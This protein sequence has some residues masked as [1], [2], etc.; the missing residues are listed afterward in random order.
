VPVWNLEDPNQEDD[1]FGLTYD[2]KVDPILDLQSRQVV[3]NFLRQQLDQFGKPGASGKNIDNVV[4][5]DLTF[6]VPVVSGGKSYTASYN[7]GDVVTFA[8]ADG[9]RKDV[10]LGQGKIDAMWLDGQAFGD[11]SAQLRKAFEDAK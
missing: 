11:L 8:A 6:T 1:T 7:G 5:A 9:K 3:R 2:E 4:P 10:K